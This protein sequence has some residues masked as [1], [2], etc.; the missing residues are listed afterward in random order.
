[1][2]NCWDTQIEFKKGDNNC[3]SLLLV[4]CTWKV[5]WFKGDV[6][7]VS[8]WSHKIQEMGAGMEEGQLIGED[9]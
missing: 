6:S 3:T 8:D 1:M 5:N 7:N 4:R 2:E 9:I